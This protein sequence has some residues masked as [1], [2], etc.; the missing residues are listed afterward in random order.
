MERSRIEFS[1]QMASMHLA[2]A[3][4]PHRAS[5]RL[6]GVL[7]FVGGTNLEALLPPAIAPSRP[8]CGLRGNGQLM[9]AINTSIGI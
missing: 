2:E 8:T 1:R 7:G 6:S 3:G 9:R 5:L 4:A